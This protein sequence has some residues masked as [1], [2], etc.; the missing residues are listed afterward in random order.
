MVSGTNPKMKKACIKL[1]MQA[2]FLRGIYCL[3][4]IIF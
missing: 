3:T 2:F 1:L 4:N